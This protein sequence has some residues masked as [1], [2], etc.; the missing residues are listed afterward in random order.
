MRIH[1]KL[2]EDLI[3]QDAMLAKFTLLLAVGV[4]A[5]FISLLIAGSESDDQTA[6]QHGMASSRPGLASPTPY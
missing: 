4:A 6:V 5:D 3:L 1:D 2:T